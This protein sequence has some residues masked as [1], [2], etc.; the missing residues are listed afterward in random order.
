MFM[1]R[2]YTTYANDEVTA[3]KIRREEIGGEQ[4]RNL[5][6]TAKHEH[7]PSSRRTQSRTFRGREGKL[8][9]GED[10]D[11]SQGAAFADQS[12]SR[13]V[14]LDVGQDLTGCGCV[15]ASLMGRAGG[16]DD[17]LHLIESDDWANVWS[18]GCFP[19]DDE[20]LSR[21]A[22]EGGG[23][24]GKPRVPFSPLHASH[25]TRSNR[26]QSRSRSPCDLGEADKANASGSRPSQGEGQDEGSFMLKG[27]DVCAPNICKPLQIRAGEG[28]V[29]ALLK[30]V[31]LPLAPARILRTSAAISRVRRSWVRSANMAAVPVWRDKVRR[32]FLFSRSPR[33]EQSACTNSTTSH[34]AH[35]TPQHHPSIT[36]N[37]PKPVQIS[38]RPHARRRGQDCL[39]VAPSTSPVSQCQT[40]LDAASLPL[41]NHDSAP[42]SWGWQVAEGLA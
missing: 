24:A 41:M 26:G 38:A 11:S 8:G 4:S 22:I 29:A 6:E 20:W 37:H 7:G 15:C 13:R 36:P 30:P 40:A 35:H 18:R 5:T 39:A 2:K 10:L 32:D 19:L 34:I 33:P 27:E 3:Y 21:W 1:R 25:C 16:A 17:R 31:A 14:P 28:L 23:E 42:R 9:L 12:A